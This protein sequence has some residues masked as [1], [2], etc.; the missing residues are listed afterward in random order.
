MKKNYL[1][2]FSIS[3]FLL[4]CDAVLILPYRVQNRTDNTIKLRVKTYPVQ[5]QMYGKRIDTVIYLNPREYVTVGYS[6]GIGFPWGTK[7]VYRK[8]PGIQNF[9]VIVND[10]IFPL[11]SSDKYWKYKRGTSVFKI[12]KPGRR[13]N[14]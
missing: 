12:R 7:S 3:I 8:Y 5:Q 14:S 6:N 10:S 9:E 13:K 4:S 11:N 1:L 2:L